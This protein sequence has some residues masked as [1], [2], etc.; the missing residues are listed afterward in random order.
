VCPARSAG[1]YGAMTSAPGQAA[2][3]LHGALQAKKKRLADR[4]VCGEPSARKAALALNE[5]RG[6][7]R[8][9]Q[10]RGSTRCVSFERRSQSRRGQYV[11]Q[12]NHKPR[13]PEGDAASAA[14]QEGIPPERLW[15]CAS[16]AVLRDSRRQEVTLAR[17]T[18]REFEHTADRMEF[19]GG[20][21]SPRRRG[22]VPIAHGIDG[23]GREQR[24]HVLP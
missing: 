6:D 13:R 8:T 4:S 2:G 7:G 9:P 18:R 15:P 12:Q 19:Q 23:R 14:P 3:I 10:H 11:C 17:K 5:A 16:R 21:P 22:A 20:E 1:F 24:R